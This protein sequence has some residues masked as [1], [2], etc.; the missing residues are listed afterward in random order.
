MAPDGSCWLGLISG[1]Q[2]RSIAVSDNNH[3][4]WGYLVGNAFSFFFHDLHTVG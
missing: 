4:P 2:H 3:R 1:A